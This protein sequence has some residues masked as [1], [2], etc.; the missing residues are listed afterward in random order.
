MSTSHFVIEILALALSPFIAVWI[1]ERLRWRHEDYRTKLWVFTTLLATRHAQF[2]DDRLRA[3]N[4]IQS[5]FA[6]TT[7]VQTCFHSY[8]DSLTGTNL[9]DPNVSAES[10]RKLQLLVEAMAKDLRLDVTGV[11]YSRGYLPKIMTQNMVADLTSSQ[12]TRTMLLHY[13]KLVGFSDDRR[14]F[15]LYDNVELPAPIQMPRIDPPR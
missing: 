10:N 6:R 11:D 13:R 14:K 4:L 8:L 3:L 1:G 5:V 7:N 15:G 9:A 2:A 12:L